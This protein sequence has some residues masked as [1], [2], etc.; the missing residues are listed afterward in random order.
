MSEKWTF[1]DKHDFLNKLEQLIS[2]G[3]SPQKISVVMPYHVHEVEEL[4]K[5]PPSKMRFFALIG[6][7]TGTVTGF[8]FTI[9]TALHYK[10]ITSGKPL[11]SVPPFI[12]IAF[13]LTILFGSLISFAGFLILSKLPSPRS[14]AAPEDYG[15]QFVIVVE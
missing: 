7:M 15:N 4:L 14:I 9:F 5:L 13:A 12:I 11:I 8:A 1:T 3:I 10:I 6:A 2:S